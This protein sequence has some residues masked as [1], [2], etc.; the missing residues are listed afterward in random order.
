MGEAIWVAHT[1]S[2]QPKVCYLNIIPS[3]V[4]SLTII[5][6]FYNFKTQKPK[7][8]MFKNSLSYSGTLIW[9]SIPVEKRNANFVKN[10][11]HG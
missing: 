10:V 4:A 1:D 2:D 9:N 8:N 6:K 3:G 11:K 5:L 7:I